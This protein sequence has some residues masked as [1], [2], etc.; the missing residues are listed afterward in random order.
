MIDQN[1]FT[2]TLQEVA[3]IVRTSAIPMNRDEILA[4]FKDMELSEEQK[5]MVF[6]YLTTPHEEPLS[7]EE[8]TESDENEPEEQTEKA[9]DPM[10]IL[11]ALAE[12]SPVFRMYREEVASLGQLSADEM[13]E[14]YHRLQQGD[15]RAVTPLLKNWL[16]QVLVAAGR[17]F[18]DQVNLED[19]IQ[20]GNMALFLKLTELVGTKLDLM[21]IQLELD[22]S[23]RE[24][25]KEYISE[26]A[27]EE[28]SEETIAGKANL[29]AQAKKTLQ[30]EKGA[31]PTLAELVDYTHMSEEE[32]QDILALMDRAEK[33]GQSAELLKKLGK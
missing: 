9:G 20:E 10:A 17:Y 32:L 21:K 18:K 14:L 16:P 15:A 29:V 8:E 11:D 25:M 4:Y 6:T 26:V 19:V 1:V 27:G 3:E 5:E 7:Q 24:A 33:A 2:E 12:Q 28:D 22:R 31:E 13:N 30:D 23:M